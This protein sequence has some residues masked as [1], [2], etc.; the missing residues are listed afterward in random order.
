M[1]QIH[2]CIRWFYSSYDIFAL[3]ELEDKNENKLLGMPLFDYISPYSN[4]PFF[5]EKETIG[6]DA[7]D[8]TSTQ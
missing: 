4:T 7:V 8:M 1:W 3:K 5:S 2:L 6:S